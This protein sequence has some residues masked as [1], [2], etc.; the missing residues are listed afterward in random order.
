MYTLS[1]LGID[2][3]FRNAPCNFG[4]AEPF[5]FLSQAGVDAL[6][7]ELASEAV[8]KNC[9]FSTDRTPWYLLNS[10]ADARNLSCFCCSCLQRPQAWQRSCF[11]GTADHSSFI[12]DLWS[13]PEVTDI[14]SAV[15]G[16]P[17][18]LGYGYEIAH[19][20]VQVTPEP[21]SFARKKNILQT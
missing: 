19:T 21:P 1:D 2:Q 18:K 14:V 6:L 11:R 7:K 15:A 5:S 17:L 9:K 16:I 4:V 13:S 12:K 8:Q 20:N 3:H 10:V